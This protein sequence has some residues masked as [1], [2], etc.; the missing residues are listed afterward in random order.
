MEIELSARL[1]DDLKWDL[2]KVDGD[3]FFWHLQLGIG[4]FSFDDE[5]AFQAASIAVKKYSEAI[6]P[7]LER[8][9]GVSLYQG[10]LLCDDQ[11]V[12]WLRMVAR[13]LPEE[14]PVFLI[15]EMEGIS[16]SET[17]ALI[18]PDRF[19]QFELILKPDPRQK[20]ENPKIGV[21]MFEGIESVLQILDRDSLSYRVIYQ[22]HLTEQWDG[23]DE[24]IVSHTLSSRGRRMLKGFEAAGGI[25]REFGAEGFEPPTY[26]SQTSRASQTALYPEK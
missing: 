23:L 17:L 12:Q 20:G 25:V 8:T 19:E 26:W 18:S 22:S 1:K 2:S 11:T 4:E 7:F 6:Q 9:I 13:N 14:L 24:I 21:C 15:F 10:S 16:R 3:N 5:M